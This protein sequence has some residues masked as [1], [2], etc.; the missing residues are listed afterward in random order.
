M[1]NQRQFIV[2]PE[3]SG[4]VAGIVKIRVP[5]TDVE[6]AYTILELEL[7]PEAGAPLHIHHHE[8]EIFHVLAGACT[9]QMEEKPQEIKAG[10][11][12]VLPKGK[13]HAFYNPSSEPARILITAVP[14]GLDS[15]F[16][17]LATLNA[18]TE[19][20]LGQMIEAINA[21]YQIEFLSD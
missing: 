8:D 21:K 18:K 4:V 13:R 12:V 11:L 10:T 16:Q 2:S 19:E 3:H 17:E 20:E 1:T 9:V 5:S 7:A 15:Y 14:G 6:N